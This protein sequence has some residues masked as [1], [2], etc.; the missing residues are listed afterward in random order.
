MAELH[1]PR[2][3]SCEAVEMKQSTS[4]AVSD[5]PVFN[6]KRNADLDFR[7]DR[8]IFLSRAL[9]EEAER[10]LNEPRMPLVLAQG[11]CRAE[12]HSAMDTKLSTAT[13][14][15]VL[16]SSKET[17]KAAKDLLRMQGINTASLRSSKAS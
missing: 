6:F 5:D 17:G 4:S 11:V 15:A 10:T 3:E 7:L 16:L 14:E 1:Y 12:K 2:S 8:C 9:L 13:A